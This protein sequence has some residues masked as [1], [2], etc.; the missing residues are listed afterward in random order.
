MQGVITKK[1][2]DDGLLKFEFEKR[3]LGNAH[4]D[5]NIKIT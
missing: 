1:N 2:R 4:D 5:N 3:G